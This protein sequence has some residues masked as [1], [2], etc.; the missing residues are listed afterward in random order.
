MAIEFL[1]QILVFVTSLAVLAFAGYFAIRAIEK[2]IEITGLS[3]VSAG[4]AILAVLT[5][6]PE[7]AVALFSIL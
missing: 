6:T 5:S 3:E 4:F 1:V 7:I 2:L